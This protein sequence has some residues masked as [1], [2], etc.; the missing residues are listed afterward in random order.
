MQ[1]LVVGAGAG[2][3]WAALH[4]AGRGPVVLLAPDPTRGSSTALAQGGIAAAIADGD[5]PSAHA[6]DTLAAG[7]GLCDPDAVRIL[8]ANAPTAIEELLA[9]GMAFDGAGAPTL[10]GGHSA[11]RVLHA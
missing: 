3:L 11:R 2:G 7:A 6:A 4:A 9:R 8:T 5:D 10:E 1:T